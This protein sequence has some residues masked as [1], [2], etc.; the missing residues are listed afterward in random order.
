[1]IQYQL[2]IEETTN[3]IHAICG[4]REMA[5][6]IVGAM[7]RKAERTFMAV[8]EWLPLVERWL[9]EGDSAETVL[10]RLDPIS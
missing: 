5:E 2:W 8:S 1:M 10:Q 9:A 3:Q 7:E 6:K 4:D